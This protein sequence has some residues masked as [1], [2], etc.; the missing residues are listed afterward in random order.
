MDIVTSIT[1]VQMINQKSHF[2][3]CFVLQVGT[4][5]LD[6]DSERDGPI[7]SY[8]TTVKYPDLY[9]EPFRPHS[10]IHLDNIEV[11]LNP[12]IFTTDMCSKTTHLKIELLV[13]KFEKSNS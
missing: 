13:R 3:D 7:I 5:Y 1:Y 12:E 4:Q 8:P 2:N 11:K 10:I 9:Y 6:G